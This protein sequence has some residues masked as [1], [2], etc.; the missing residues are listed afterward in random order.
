MS[1]TE[2]QYCP[3][4][5][6]EA[7]LYMGEGH[8]SV[9]FAGNIGVRHARLDQWAREHPEFAQALG[10]GRAR[11]VMFWEHKLAEI[12]RTGMGNASAAI[13]GL[14]HAAA[15]WAAVDEANQ[16]AAGTSLQGRNTAR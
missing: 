11:N 7:V 4:Y 3:F 6:G 12:A 15:E 5:C 2:K 8:G 10:I 13:Y 14:K 1:D 9:A 16:Q